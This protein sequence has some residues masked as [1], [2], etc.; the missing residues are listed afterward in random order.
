MQARLVDALGDVVERHPGELVAVVSHAD[1]IKSAIA[2]YTGMHLDAFQRIVVSPASVSV[3]TVGP[4]GVAVL[5]TN[6]TGSLADLVPA[7]PAEGDGRSTPAPAAGDDHVVPAPAEG[8]A[9][10]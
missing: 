1:P 7:G 5:R 4:G 8:D 9:R 3:V 2:H 6:D 10:G